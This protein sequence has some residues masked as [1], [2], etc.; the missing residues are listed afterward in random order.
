MPAL[1]GDHV[2]MADEGAGD[3]VE[4]VGVGAAAVQ[5]AEPGTARVPPLQRVQAEAVDVERAVAG[6]PAGERKRR[7]PVILP[8]KS[9]SWPGPARGV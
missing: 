3:R 2:A 7:Q 4:P 1:V 9:F 6:R 8:P 5:E